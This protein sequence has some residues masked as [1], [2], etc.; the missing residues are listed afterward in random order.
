MISIK[1]IFEKIF[2]KI[3]K[4][5]KVRRRKRIALNGQELIFQRFWS[6]F[7]PSKQASHWNEILTQNFKSSKIYILGPFFRRWEYPLLKIVVLFWG[8]WDFYITGE[9]R[10]NPSGLAHSCIGFRLPKAD[11]EF[12]FPYWM[13]YVDW[14]E[15]ETKSPYIR[16]G[17]KYALDQLQRSINQTFGR[18]SEQEFENTKLRAVIVASHLKGHRRSLYETCNTAIDCNLAGNFNAPLSVP[19]YDLLRQYHFNLCPEN[20]LGQG[21]ITEKIP[22]AFLA[23]TIP[24]A[25]C[26]PE[27]LAM[28]FNPKAVV[29][30]YGL[31]SNEIVQTLRNLT[32]N[33]QAFDALRSQ[34]L[35]IKRPSLRPLIEFISTASER[36]VS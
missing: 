25:Y 27:D 26:R 17:Q 15:L 16:Y 19:K 13:N 34:P 22:E 28:D 30:L 29:N 14:P 8:K 32:N 36:K 11:A 4:E 7:D 6:D 35:I 24:I 5:I 23:G 9:N 21:Y 2:I 20:S 10:D 31:S 1:K 33:Y 3:G 18:V 12:R